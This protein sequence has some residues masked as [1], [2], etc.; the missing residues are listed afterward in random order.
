MTPGSA[1]GDI[2]R[3]SALWQWVVLAGAGLVL[4]ALRLRRRRTPLSATLFVGAAVLLLTLDLF[5]A[6]MGYN[7]AIPKS[8]AIV[9]TTGAIRYLQ[10]QRP[11]RF[12][13]ASASSAFQPLPA[14]LA[15]NFHLYDARGYDYPT[16]T[17][18]DTLWRRYVNNAPTLA[19]PTEIA[20]IT[21][22]SLRALDLLSVSDVLVSPGRRAAHRAWTPDRVSRH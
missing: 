12:V 1:A 6:N 11:N 8:H 5:R 14:D 21:P 19:Q 7:P 16:E 18:Y 17:T 3:M 2:V 15:M 20:P 13:G 4:I 22:T 9:P 10:A